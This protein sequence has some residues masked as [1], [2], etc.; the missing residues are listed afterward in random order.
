MFTSTAAIL[1]CELGL[2]SLSKV[3]RNREISH[4][5]IKH[6]YKPSFL[7]FVSVGGSLVSKVKSH[8]LRQTR[9]RR[10]TAKWSKAEHMLEEPFPYLA[11]VGSPGNEVM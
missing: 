1:D 7:L 5:K 3:E 4:R 10:P 6:D 2:L 11:N 9:R 8:L